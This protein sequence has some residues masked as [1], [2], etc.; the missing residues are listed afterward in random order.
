MIRIQND[1]MLFRF[2]VVGVAVHNGYVLTQQSPADGL[3]ALPGGHVELGEAAEHA[4]KREL[5]EELG[6]DVAVGRLLWV[7]EN[8]Y[9][10][11]TLGI[12][13]LG[14]YFQVAA[15]AAFEQH[16]TD[17]VWGDED[18]HP[19]KYQWHPI[20]NLTEI[21]IYPAF[22]REA[23]VSLPEHIQHIVITPD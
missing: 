17:P 10:D 18:G 4:L 8:H 16:G 9:I 19:M 11:E 7:V 3:W 2:R 6:L 12:H 20:E 15:A 23:L 21:Q 14:F 22:L 5:R 13:E 1:T